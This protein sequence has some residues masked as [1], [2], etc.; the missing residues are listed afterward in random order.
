M[1]SIMSSCQI[2]LCLILDQLEEKQIHYLIQVDPVLPCVC[3]ATDH[4]RHQSVVRTSTQSAVASCATFLFLPH[5]DVICDLLL[6]RYTL[7][8]YLFVKSVASCLFP[9]GYSSKFQI[10]G[11]CPEVQPLTH[12]STILTGKTLLSHTLENTCR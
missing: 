11:L 7:S 9:V 10:G 8:W 1:I 4:R 3:S 2:R 6:S 12:L 5:F